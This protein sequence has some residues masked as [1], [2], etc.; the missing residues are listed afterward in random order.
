MD[1]GAVRFYTPDFHLLKEIDNAT[2]IFTKRWHT[3]G[4]FEIHLDRMEGYIKKDNRIIFDGDEYKNGIIK[5]IFQDTDGSVT[6]KGFTMLWILKNRLTVPKQGEDYVYYNAPV[7]DIMVDLVEKN[8]VDPLDAKRKIPYFSVA[9]SSGRGEKLAYQSSYTEVTECL[10]ELSKYSMLG[11]AVRMDIAKKQY[12]F[13]VL[14]GVDRTINQQNCP[15]VVFRKEY[16]NLN[17]TTYTLNDSNTKNCA[18]TGGQGEGAARAVYVVG[19]ELDGE[20]RREVFVDARDVEDV[21][22]LPERGAAKLANMR[23]EEN[24]ESEITTEWYEKRWKMGDMVTVLDEDSGITLNDYVVE[25]E[26]SLDADGYTVIPT[27]GVP[28]KGLS[29]GSSSS[30]SG[31]SGRGGNDARYTYTKIAPADIWEVEHNLGKF[32]SVTVVDSA[33]SV[34]Q[35]EIE[36]IDRNNVRVTFTGAFAGFA[37]LN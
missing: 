12:V 25:V 29:G 34:V 6:I 35:G 36:Y 16:D 8:A 4:Q 22:E 15:P 33:G 28:E 27:F 19:G 13:E 32:P 31:S 7:E 5:Y 37:Y 30:G 18:Y 10:Q 21:S 9:K 20:E 23:P 2:V 11:V 24:F 17:N 1:T 26:E 14:E 3:Y